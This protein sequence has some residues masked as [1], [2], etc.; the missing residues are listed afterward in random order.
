MKEL[1]TARLIGSRACRP[2]DVALTICCI[3]A[4]SAAALNA[5]LDGAG[6]DAAARP[7][8][9]NRIATVEWSH[10]CTVILEVAGRVAALPAK[11][12]LAHAVPWRLHIP[13][14]DSRFATMLNT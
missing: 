7:A 4:N 1:S 9:W 10:A 14:S 2:R 13:R 11:A 8:S 5:G 6:P 3:R 12:A